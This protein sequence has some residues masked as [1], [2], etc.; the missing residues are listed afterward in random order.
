MDYV[1]RERYA[2]FWQRLFLSNIGAHL[3]PSLAKMMYGRW[4][5]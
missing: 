1:F 5:R 3:D 4:V 2:P